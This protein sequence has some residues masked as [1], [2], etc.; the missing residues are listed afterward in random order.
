MAFIGH[1]ITLSEGSRA[2]FDAEGG[3]RAQMP[4]LFAL[5]RR[6]CARARAHTL[7]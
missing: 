4:E 5:L 1:L 3:S 6:A 2:D 7:F